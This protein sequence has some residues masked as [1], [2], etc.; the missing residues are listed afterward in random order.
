MS[1]ITREGE[2][3]PVYKFKNGQTVQLISGSPPM[4][5]ADSAQVRHPET[6]QI[7]KVIQVV[8][9]YHNPVAGSVEFRQLPETALTLCE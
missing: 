1:L 6:K 7:M 8:C 4:T 3:I 5:V 2:T 9:V